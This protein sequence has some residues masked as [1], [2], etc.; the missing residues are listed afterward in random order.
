[1]GN[2]S[3][4]H[5][6]QLQSFVR[7][8]LILTIIIFLIS[9]GVIGI[10]FFEKN[11]SYTDQSIVSKISK[12][13]E[14]SAGSDY[15]IKFDSET[16]TLEGKEIDSYS[17]ELSEKTIS[18]IVKSPKWIQRE[19]T[20]QF[21]SLESPEEYADLIL[22]VSKQYSDEIA[23]SIAC[24]PLG[25]V[26]S[27]DVIRD[28]TFFLYENDKWIQYAD[29]IDYDNEGGDY[30][31]T[32]RYKVLENDTVKEFEYPRDIYYW[33]VV[34]PKTLSESAEYIYEKIWRE[35]LFYHNDLGYPLL[36]EKLSTIEYLW[37]CKSYSQPANRLWKWSMENHPTA[38]EAISY[39][40]GKTVPHQATGD[41]PGQ[42]N[43]IAHE[44]NGWCGELQRIAIAAQRAALIPSIGAC[45][46]GEDHVWREF[47]E[48]GWHQNDN[49]WTDSGGT[50]NTPD[51][52]QYGWGKYMSAVFTWIGD[53][54]IYDVTPTYIHPED[55]TTIKFVVKD[56]YLHPV[57]G[58]RVTVT[59]MGIKDI[60]WL[61]NTI[62]EKIQEI[63]DKLPD[64][65]K[66]KI[67]QAIYE[68][69]QERIDEIPDIIDGLTVTTWSY[70]DI[71]GECTLELGKN[72]EYLFVIQQ[73][74]N[75]RKPW[76][77]AKNNAIRIYNNTQ[78]KTFHIPFLDFS[79][80]VQR[81]ISKEMPEGDC[82]FDVSFDTKAYQLQKN[83]RNDLI[84]TYDIKGDIDFFILDEE[85]FGKY[86]DGKRFS[87]FNYIE[88]KNSDFSLSAEKK[89]WYIVFRN[90]A[91]RTNVVLDFSI[92]V[93]VSTDIDKVEIVSPDT[94][95]FDNPIFN[96]GDV[97]NIS[98]IATDDVLLI[99][100]NESIPVPTINGEWSYLWD[101]S[102]AIVHD[103]LI[104]ANCGDAYDEIFISLIDTIP[105]EIEIIEPQD[106]EIINADSLIISGH[107][108]DNVDVEKVEVAI[109][110]GEYVEANGIRNWSIEWDIS[111]LALGDHFIF[112]K[113]IDLSG[114]EAIY[115][116]SFVKNESGHDWNPKINDFY[117]MPE[118]PT[119][120]SN[121]IVYANVTKNSPF[122]IR[123]V[124]L[125]CDNGTETNTFEMYWYADNPVQNRH[126]EDPLYNEPNDPIFGFELGQFNTGDSIIYW[127]EA[128]DTAN[129]FVQSNEKS[130]MID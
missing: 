42:P 87:C 45:N 125:Y 57:D 9:P 80:R 115:R 30:Y 95:V 72:H 89:D 58:A 113:A 26:P 124:V 19:L 49:W 75:L 1:M 88:E 101:T 122:D 34:Q 69:I 94:S 5:N 128:F 105:P 29:I 6:K 126:E 74:N 31:S 123:R 63:W 32:I 28:N 91:H 17:K 66:G 23:F 52:Y 39:W 18:A 61:K 130:F 73:G 121:V 103:H 100:D 129:N 8:I 11:N 38:I 12:E 13:I 120:T 3:L 15:Y 65:I 90:H 51:V 85:N 108:M 22:S 67:L 41:R 83:V 36:K 93:E 10:G 48:R 102:E 119:N 37:D 78:D 98:G 114:R 55:R 97:V 54:S 77:L 99:I 33:Y 47:Y 44:H 127:V 24:S 16:Q 20:R 46:I 43:I 117:H 35:Y 21:Q 111:G 25:A 104:S 60:T 4:K 14:I 40:I 79:N 92:Q 27:V 62:W 68:R 84:G 71:N 70:T 106:G 64:L 76:Q 7:T 59:V 56:R 50:V 2:Y 81:H 107:S 82:I 110:Y 96:V 116:V 118:S 112:A 53:D 109:D 86:M